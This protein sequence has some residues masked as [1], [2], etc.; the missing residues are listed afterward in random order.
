[1]G[2]E[3]F[4]A[5]LVAP[6]SQYNS[7]GHYNYRSLEDITMAVKTLLKSFKGCQC[8]L[9]YDAIMVGDWHYIKATASFID[10]DGN[11]TVAHGFARE[12]ESKKGADVSQITGSAISYAGKYAMNALFLLDDTKDADTEEY[13][14]QYGNQQNQYGNQQQFD[15]QQQFN[16]GY[17][18]GGFNQ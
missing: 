14:S 11:K 1:M 5:K 3:D 10:E 7:F 18:N 15:N 12:P 13:Q 9:D 4:R 6:K 8:Q 17:Y 2:I 16:N